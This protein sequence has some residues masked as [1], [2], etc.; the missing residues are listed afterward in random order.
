MSDTTPPPPKQRSFAELVAET[1]LSYLEQQR[2]GPGS[3]LVEQIVAGAVLIIP[4]TVAAAVETLDEH[5]NLHAPVIEGD[6]VARSVMQAQNTAK[7]GPCLEAFAADKTIVVD[8]LTTDPRWPGFSALARELDIRSMVCAP[9]QAA[10]RQV[11]VTSLMSRGRNFLGDEDTE[12]MAGIFAAHAAIAMIGAARVEDVVSALDRR[13]VIGQAKGVLM[14]RFKMTPEVAF[15][16]L[17][18]TSQRT[19]RKLFD[20]CAELPHRRPAIPPSTGEL[21]RHTLR[22]PEGGATPDG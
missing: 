6:D 1:A 21:N 17:V 7:Q 3:T 8:D 11:G 20:V 15:V 5:G 12:V 2:P 22:R 9:M 18:A 19:N 16:T 10:G 13:D 14:E 4:G